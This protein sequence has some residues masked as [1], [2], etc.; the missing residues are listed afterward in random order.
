MDITLKEAINNNSE[1]LISYYKNGYSNTLY[2]YITK[3]DATK[4]AIYL[5]GIPLKIDIITRI[6]IIWKS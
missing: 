4:K 1:V 3:L 6:E 2:G 5:D